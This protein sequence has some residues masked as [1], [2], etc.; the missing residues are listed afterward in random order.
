MTGEGFTIFFLP[1]PHGLIQHFT[2]FWSPK[3]VHG[4]C[5]HIMYLYTCTWYLCIFM[6]YIT[7]IPVLSNAGGC[8]FALNRDIFL[9]CLRIP[10]KLWFAV[11]MK[12]GYAHQMLINNWMKT[13][14][15]PLIFQTNPADA[16]ANP[17]IGSNRSP[18]IP[19]KTIKLTQVNY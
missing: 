4:V 10:C 2:H 18:S 13:G 8:L 15:I 16:V 6:L 3:Y 12:M 7:S 14:G 19:T 9:E 17:I 11:C 5:R 1:W